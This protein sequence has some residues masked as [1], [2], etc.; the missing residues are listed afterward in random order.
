MSTFFVGIDMGGSGTRAALATADGEVLATGRGGPSG[1]RGGAVGRRDIQRALTAALA[2]IAGRIG[3]AACSIHV[4]VRGLSVPGR[5]EAVAMTLGERL[6]HAEV[7]IS[8]DAMVAIWGALAGGEGVAVLA[9]TGSIA[10]ARSA[11]GRI[12]RAGGYGYLVGD[13][14]SAFWIGRQA[15][16]ACLRALDHRGPPTCLTDLVCAAASKT[17]PTD[18]VAW[19]HADHD[20]VPR[21]AALAPLVSR[22]AETSDDV[23]VDILRT[24]ACDLADLAFAA[25][26]RVWSD[27]IPEGVRLACVGGVWAA[28]GVLRQPFGSAVLTLM[29]GATIT[30]PRLA[31]VGGAVLL[32]MDV[33]SAR[34]PASVIQA[35]E[36]TLG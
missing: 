6:P 35:L 17:T 34:V 16:S 12:A 15:F 33:Q 3:T 22:A 29:P 9:G 20:E 27:Q 23:A 31:P 10:M 36:Q 24:A 7:R 25:A 13:E 5:H 1:A 30:R 26:R 4:G 8:N 11:D 18:L 32:A 19:L 14:G 28:G 2:P 21:L